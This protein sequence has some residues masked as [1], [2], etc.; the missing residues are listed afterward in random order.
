MESNTIDIGRCG[1]DAAVDYLRKRGFLI[2]ERN[3]RNGRY[4]IDIIAERWDEIHF[5]EVKTR[6]AGGWTTPEQAFDRHKFQSLGRAASLYLALKR[7]ELE[8]VFDL[9]CVERLP[10]DSLD[11][12]FIESVMQS[13]W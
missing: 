9:C 2:R 7:C 12:R 6:K 13:H 5:V 8:P 4:E 11:I 3:W 1:E 10:D